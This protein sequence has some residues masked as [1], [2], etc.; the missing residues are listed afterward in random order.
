MAS[1]GGACTTAG[2]AWRRRNVARV[3]L[4]VARN[5]AFE[6]AFTLKNDGVP[7][8]LTNIEVEA[9]IRASG[10]RRETLLIDFEEIAFGVTVDAAAGHITLAAPLGVVAS[11]PLVP[12]DWDMILTP[13][14]GQ[15][16]PVMAGRVDIVAG[17]TRHD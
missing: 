3:D 2:A 13:L 15:P 8:D 9:Q 6:Q 4:V 11:L 1:F 17:T 5:V 16:F 14:G 7:Y 10:R 12:A